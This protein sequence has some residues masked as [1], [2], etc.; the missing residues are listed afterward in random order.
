MRARADVTAIRTAY[1]MSERQACE[2]AGIA[3]SSYR[4]Q[5]QAPQRDEALKARLTA[6][7]QKYPR[8]GSPRLCVLVRREQI[9][10]HKRVERIYREAG[11]SLRRK[12]RKRLMRQRAPVMAAQAANEEWALDFV[13]DALA[14]ARHVRIL[15]RGGCVHP[16]VFG[17]GDRHVDG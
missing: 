5:T 2:L 11:L 6:L 8:F 1:P 10:N 4:Y 15:T 9:H 12:N 16:R 3:V 7:A 17:A 14:S 13:G